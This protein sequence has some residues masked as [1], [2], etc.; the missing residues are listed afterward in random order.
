MNKFSI[1]DIESLTGIKSHTIRIWE[2]RYGLIIPKR[3]DTNIRYYDDKDLCNFLNI[4][5]LNDNGF[6]ISE[7]AKMSETQMGEKVAIISDELNTSCSQVTLLSSAM[8]S[9]DEKKF[10]EIL[11]ASIEK[12]GIEFTVTDVLF[13][14]M[15][16][17]GVMWQTSKINSAHEHFV[18]HLIKQKLICSIDKLPASPPIG[19]RFLLFLP[20]GETHE[21][22]LL[23]A[24]YLIKARGHQVLYLGQNLPCEDLFKV[25]KFYDPDYVLSVFT[26]V[27]IDSDINNLLSRIID[28]LPNWPLL[29]A[30]PRIMQCPVTPKN[31]LTV[32][33]SI[34]E[35]VEMLDKEQSL[36]LTTH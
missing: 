4:S 16:K 33:N 22:G 10:D 25:S 30:G 20:E 32:I 34:E 11:N 5:T 2:Q 1:G 29:V 19:K 7:I 15:R 14:F 24:N 6:K 9:L 17:I 28:N 23:F 27:L 13:P 8:L 18:T 36:E 3:T 35:L 12:S 26:S 21:V 31:G